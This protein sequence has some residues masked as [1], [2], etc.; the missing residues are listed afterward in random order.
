MTSRQ[1]GHGALQRCVRHG[2]LAVVVVLAATWAS[3]GAE[4]A[5]PRRYVPGQDYQRLVDPVD[6]DGK[7]IPVIEF[8]LYGCPHCYALDSVVAQ[9]QRNL[10]DDVVFRRVPVIFGADGRFYARLF[11]T[12]EILGVLHRVHEKI[13][14]TIH[15]R[16]KDLTNLA[17][18]RAFFHA[19]GVD[20][21]RFVRVFNSPA[22]DRKIARAA[23]LM[24]AFNVRAVP[25]LGVAGRY[26]ITGRMAGSNQAM[27]DV[28]EYLL[29]RTRAVRRHDER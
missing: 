21:E 9:W 26:W 28:A 7:R 17:A 12:A 11:Y 22:V 24:R 5:L 10:P 3:A 18:A 6:Y 4:Q 2:V 13:F 23:R 27:F 8:F 29:R 20:S 15:Q 19:Q 16:H 14:E 25:S 1:G